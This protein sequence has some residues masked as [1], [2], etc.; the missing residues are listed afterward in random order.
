MKI[1]QLTG[2]QRFRADIEGLRA[3]S[4]LAVVFYHAQ[5]PGFSGG[6]V[7]V[8]VF[9]VISGFLICNLLA[10][11]IIE[12]GRIDLVRFWAR[13]ARRLL[14]N[15]SLTLVIT[16]IVSSFIMPGYARALFGREV[17]SAALYL[18][19]YQF[20]AKAVDYFHFD[21]P[22]SPVMHFWSLNVEEQFYIV[23]PLTLL[24][25]SLVLRQ[26]PRAT[27]LILLVT[28]C[29]VSFTASAVLIR[30][31]QPLVFFHTETRCW[32]LALGGLVASGSSRSVGLR[33]CSA[34]GWLGLLVIL[35]SV[36][37]F[38]DA[39]TYPGPWALVPALAT[40]A[41]LAAHETGRNTFSPASVLSA[42]PFRWIGRRSYSWYLWH[43][44]IIVFALALFPEFPYALQGCRCKRL[45]GFETFGSKN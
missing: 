7:G 5:I 20:A 36:A 2:S 3:V 30:E 29:L 43:W 11:E 35:A 14:P 4:I 41:V 19:N 10:Q 31:N 22:L 18:S 44:P 9:F 16:L 42:L 28:I 39:M 27:S 17:A 37:S 13:R 32:E 33:S 1:D 15:A 8:D 40:A 6:F 25:A 38:N 45:H 34:I 23:W 21:D 26:N 24:G 12:T